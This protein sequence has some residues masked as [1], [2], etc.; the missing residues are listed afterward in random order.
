MGR[1]NED[2]KIQGVGAKFNNTHDKVVATYNKHS[3]PVGWV[4][5][6]LNSINNQQKYTFYDNIGVEVVNYQGVNFQYV[7][8]MPLTNDQNGFDVLTG[9]SGYER[10]N[11]RFTGLLSNNMPFIG[12]LT[13]KD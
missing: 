7:I 2:G 13:F 3:K 12:C 6:Y 1:K 10:I 5:T 4:K 8:D 9:R 11:I